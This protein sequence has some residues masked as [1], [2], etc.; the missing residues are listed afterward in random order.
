MKVLIQKYNI[1]IIKPCAPNNRISNTYV[2]NIRIEE[3]N[4]LFYNNGWRLKKFL[5]NPHP[6]ICFLIVEMEGGR[7]RER[8]REKHQ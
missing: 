8:K 5:K 7:E 4:R 2:K 3:I 1:T 6:M